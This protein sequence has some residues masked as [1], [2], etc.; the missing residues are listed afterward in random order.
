MTSSQK[1]KIPSFAKHLVLV[2]SLVFTCLVSSH[3]F[4]QTAT[5]GNGVVDSDGNFYNSI[6]VSNGQE[7]MTENLKTTRFANGDLISKIEN[8]LSWSSASTS[9][10]SDYQ[11][12]E[13]IANTY[14]R[15]YN[16]F[17]TID[18]RNVCPSGWHVPS[19]LEWTRFTNEIGGLGVAGSILK[20]TGNEFWQA[21]NADATD[22]IG[23]RALPNGCRYDGGNYNNLGTYAYFWTATELDTTF[24]W[25]RSLKYDV[26]TAFRNF[27]KKQNGF[28]I[29]CVKN[30]PLELIEK[31]NLKVSIFPNP[32]T[33]SIKMEYNHSANFENAIVSILNSQGLV[34]K[35]FNGGESTLDLSELPSGLYII[36][37]Q[38]ENSKETVR[39]VKM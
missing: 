18:E 21:P 36:V 23:F 30:Q 20:A 28:A 15:L 32:F 14:G 12:N 13:I 22:A 38:L 17:T 25:F 8:N 26:P 6:I 34:C 16:F 33:E 39:I 27:T 11:G 9:A 29:R 7:W 31:E 2:K 19:N 35:V 5:P 4:S 1:I 3:F 24:S 37:V 10:F